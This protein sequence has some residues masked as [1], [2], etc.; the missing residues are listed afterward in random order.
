M[1]QASAAG[2]LQED[3]GVVRR[4]E[5]LIDRNLMRDSSLRQGEPVATRLQYCK[6]QH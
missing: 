4:A 1:F 6:L 3:R 2:F 5:N